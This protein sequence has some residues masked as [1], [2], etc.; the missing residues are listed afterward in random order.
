[1]KEEEWPNFEAASSWYD[2]FLFPEA[3]NPRKGTTY[4]K[5]YN[6]IKRAYKVI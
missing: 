1:M 2:I 4:T 5:Q 6:G 3:H